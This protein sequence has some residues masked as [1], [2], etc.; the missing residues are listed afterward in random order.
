V[1]HLIGRDDFELG[2]GG[3]S[4]EAESGVEEGDQDVA[5]LLAAEDLLEG[6][7]G[8][9]SAKLMEETRCG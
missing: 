1:R 8:G 6:D 2:N 9:G 7:V 5:A 3:L 4:G